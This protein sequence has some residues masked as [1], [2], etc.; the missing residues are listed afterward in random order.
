MGFVPQWKVLLEEEGLAWD[1]ETAA[2]KAVRLEEE[3]IAWKGWTAQRD[4]EIF[5][6]QQRR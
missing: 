2:Q 3:D 1:A 5:A 6:R 4:A